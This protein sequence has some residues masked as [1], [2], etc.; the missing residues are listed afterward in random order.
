[1]LTRTLVHQKY[2]PDLVGDDP[3]WFR[4]RGDEHYRPFGAAEADAM[5][6]AMKEAG[7]E[8]FWDL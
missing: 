2:R 4:S 8:R 5:R 6:A 3:L 1:M 7:R